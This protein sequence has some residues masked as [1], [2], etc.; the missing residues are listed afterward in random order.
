[1]DTR[2]IVTGDNAFAICRWVRPNDFWASGSGRISYERENIDLA[3]VELAFKLARKIGSSCTA[4]DFVRKE[5]GSLAVHEINY[6]FTASV[7]DERPGYWDVDLI[8]HD[9]AFNPQG[10]IVELVFDQSARTSNSSRIS[11]NTK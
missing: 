2:V 1:M 7:Y 10:W 9:D 5:D 6:G 4:F 8:W 3:C 11:Y